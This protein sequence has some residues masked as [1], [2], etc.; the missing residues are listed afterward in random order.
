[1]G[2]TFEVDIAGK[3]RRRAFQHPAPTEIRMILGA[4]LRRDSALNL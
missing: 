4:S 1:M 3:D 2:D